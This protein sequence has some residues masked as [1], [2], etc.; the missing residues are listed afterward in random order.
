MDDCQFFAQHGRAPDVVRSAR[1]FDLR[2]EGSSPGPI[3]AFFD[4]D[5]IE[6]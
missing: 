1:L 2:L 3:D 6:G 4:I 5:R